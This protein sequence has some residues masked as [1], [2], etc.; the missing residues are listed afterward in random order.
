MAAI[1]KIDCTI[2]FLEMLEAP[3]SVPPQPQSG[4]TLALLK[5]ER[6]SVA[7]YRFLYNTVGSDWYWFERRLL[8]DSRLAA[9]VQD[10]KVELWVL[11]GGGQP[12]G[13]AELDFRQ[14]ESKDTVDLGYFG[15]LPDFI[16]R[17]LGPYL[18]GAALERAWS[19][20]PKRVTVNTNSLD[21]PRA[22]PL[23]QRFGF[24]PIRREQRRFD[25]PWATGVMGQ[26]LAS[27]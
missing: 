10:P 19:K 11:Y 27:R 21:H 16:G 7:F 23:Y 4:L 18:L 1:P 17:G 13:Y 2:T 26:P 3:S 20:G 8:S 24:A 15:L 12:A 22:L 25:D 5:V 14:L 9:I 6:P